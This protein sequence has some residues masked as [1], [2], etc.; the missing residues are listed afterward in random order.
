MR[1]GD[2]QVRKRAGRTEVKGED[3]QMRIGAGV[4]V[5]DWL[6]GYNKQS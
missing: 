1:V 6:E 3:S 2:R 5:R 4:K